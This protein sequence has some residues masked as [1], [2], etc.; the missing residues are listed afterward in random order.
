MSEW[1]KVDHK[2]PKIG[3]LVLVFRPQVL[4]EDFTDRPI[5]CA[6]WNGK[7]FDCFHQP[8]SWK[9][10]DKPKTWNEELEKRQNR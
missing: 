1:I 7:R 2:L 8:V 6:T 4:T 9:R 3:E 5:C 10:I